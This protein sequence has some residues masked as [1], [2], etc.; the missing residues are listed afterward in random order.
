MTHAGI[1]LRKQDRLDGASN[2]GVWKVRM[3]FLL[4]GFGLKD[5][6]KKGVAEPSDLDKLR[7]FQRQVAKTKRMILDGLRDHVVLHVASKETTKEMWDALVMLYQDL[8]ENRKM[9][10]KEKLRTIKMQKGENVTSY[11]TR[12]QGVRDELVAVGEKLVDG[13]LVRVAINMF[14]KGWAT[15][16]Q[17]IT[18]RAKLPD[19]ECLWTDFIQEELR[20]SLV[21]ASSNSG[22]AKGNKC[23]RKGENSQKN[24]KKLK[25]P[26]A[27]FHMSGNREFLSQLEEKDLQVHIELGDN[28]EYATKGV[29]TVGFERDFGSTLHLK[30]V[31]Y[32]PRLKKNLVS[33]AILEDKGYDVVFNKG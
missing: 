31:L 5:Y 25:D 4:D 11:L 17:G 22:K 33:V 16:V 9:I 2:F 28:G 1:G 26:S 30:D 29:G 21:R 18:G 19:W 14:S 3:M 10:L 12:I 6:A 27:A 13:E 20:L 23:K 24:D 32:V 15:F 8:S 7:L